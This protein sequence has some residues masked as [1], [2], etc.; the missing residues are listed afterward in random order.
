MRLRGNSRLRW[1]TLARSTK[2]VTS[3]LIEVCLGA[4]SYS[5]GP[6]TTNGSFITNAAAEELHNLSPC[7]RSIRETVRSCSGVVPE[8]TAQEVWNNFARCWQ[9]DSSQIQTTTRQPVVE[10]S[11]YH[12]LTFTRLL[13]RFQCKP[14]KP[15]PSADFKPN[16]Q[17]LCTVNVEKEEE[18]RA[19]QQLRRPRLWV[20]SSTGS[21][22]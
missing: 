17:P 10:T 19:C 18:V 15:V 12:S 8:Q 2:S 1:R 20:C 5:R 4:V 7:L 6:V 11:R 13:H 14:L 22:E 21:C 3:S 16:F 9:A